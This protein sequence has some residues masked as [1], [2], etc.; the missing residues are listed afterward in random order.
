M[1]RLVWKPLGLF[2]QG[3]DRVVLYLSGGA[4]P[5]NGIVS[6]NEKPTDADIEV[7]Y[8]D[9]KKFVQKRSIEGFEASVEAYTFPNELITQEKPHG[10]AYRV[11]LETGY[12]IHILYNVLI[13]TND[14]QYVTTD[15][16]VSVSLFSWNLSTIPLMFGDNKVGSHLIVESN[17]THP[18]VITWLEALLYGTDINAPYLPMP[19]EIIAVFQLNSAF[20]ITDNGNGTFTA[21]GPDEYIQ[22]IDATTYKLITPSIDYINGTTYKIHSW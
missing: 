3:V 6:V 2:H 14:A 7:K 21:S 8:Y 22:M 5:W 12:E 13:N 4:V 16:T 18:D 20:V 17:T 1:R 10:M 11:M 9:G 19:D 15:D